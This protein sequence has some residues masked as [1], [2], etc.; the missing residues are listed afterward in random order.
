MDLVGKKCTT[1]MNYGKVL[2]VRAE[3][4]TEIRMN[5]PSHNLGLKKR[6]I[7]FPLVIRERS[8]GRE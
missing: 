4:I 5:C 8:E 2:G 3:A 6:K 1:Q 7:L